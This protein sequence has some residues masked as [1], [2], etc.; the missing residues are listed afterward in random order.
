M[1]FDSQGEFVPFRIFVGS[2]HNALL[3]AYAPHREGKFKSGAIMPIASPEKCACY[4][5][6]K[7]EPG[8]ITMVT[9]FQ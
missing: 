9:D 1:A 2:P 7:G 8:F 4:C 3:T 5:V 6:R